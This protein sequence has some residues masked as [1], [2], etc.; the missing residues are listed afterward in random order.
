MKITYTGDELREIIAAHVMRAH[1]LTRDEVKDV[2]WGVTP[3]HDKALQ[4]TVTAEENPIGPPRCIAKL[5]R[6][7]MH[8][9]KHVISRST[10]NS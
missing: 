7:T 4:I 1:G 10:Q 2:R 3:D 9:T 8:T 6:C 5:R